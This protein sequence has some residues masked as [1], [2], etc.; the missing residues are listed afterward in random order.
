M[1]DSKHTLPTIQELYNDVAEYKKKDE[2]N[3]LLSQQ[4]PANWVKGHPFI[5]VDAYDDQGKKIGKKPYPYL[6]IDKVEYLLRRIFKYYK[7]EVMREG[8]MFNAVYCAVR[9][10]Y[11]D[12][13]TGEWMYHDGVGASQL[14]TAKGKSAA[15]LANLNNG[16]V[17]MALPLA[18]TLAIKDA[19]DNFGDL[20]GANLNRRDTIQ[21]AVDTKLMTKTDKL[22]RIKELFEVEGLIMSEE[23]KMNIERIIEQEEELSYDK[24]IKALTKAQPKNG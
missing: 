17:M 8:Q 2:V 21:V 16:A 19:C 9:V 18:K 22:D 14:Q 4:P 3:V 24:A 13:A 23:D 6:P 15:D 7:I 11:K 5:K 10:H 12:V 1:S 20:F